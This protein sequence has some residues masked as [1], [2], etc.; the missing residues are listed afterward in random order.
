LAGRAEEEQNTWPKLSVILKLLNF[1]DQC[2]ASKQSSQHV[3]ITCGFANKDAVSQIIIDN[4]RYYRYFL[5]ER[6]TLSG[7]DVPSSSLDAA[8]DQVNKILRLVCNIYP[9]T[10]ASMAGRYAGRERERGW[11]TA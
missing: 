2:F 3:R 10:G 9:P 5:F 6:K 1:V 11:E 4:Y 7:E 8:R